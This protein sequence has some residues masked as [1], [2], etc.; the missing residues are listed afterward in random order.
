MHLNSTSRII[1]K[2]KPWVIFN[3]K[4]FFSPIGKRSGFEVLFF[5]SI[6]ATTI[7]VWHVIVNSRK[8]LVILNISWHSKNKIKAIL[9]TFKMS[10]EYQSVWAWIIC[11]VYC[12]WWFLS[13]EFCEFRLGNWGWDFSEIESKATCTCE[14][15]KN[16]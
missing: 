4:S 8:H 9:I 3:N 12:I 16:M 13:F 7:N 15:C 2:S 6:T 14:P 10:F 11:V 1:F 5:S